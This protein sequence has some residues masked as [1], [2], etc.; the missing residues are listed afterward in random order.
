MIF[1]IWDAWRSFTSLLGG[2]SHVPRSPLLVQGFLEKWTCR[3]SFV[4]DLMMTLE[5]MLDGRM[6]MLIA[7]MHFSE[8]SVVARYF[9]MP[10]R[11]EGRAASWSFSFPTIR[12]VVEEGC[13]FYPILFLTVYEIMKL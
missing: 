8:A 7:I 11:C 3:F 5:K 10:S 1:I 13:S 2:I 9:A 6:A 12:S 4:Y